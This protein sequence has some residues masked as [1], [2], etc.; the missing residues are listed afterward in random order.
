MHEYF[1]KKECDKTQN[2]RGGSHNA[3]KK[4]M[5]NEAFKNRKKRRRFHVN[6][7]EQEIAKITKRRISGV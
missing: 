1:E 5:K 3:R 4:R 2:R 7:S 6:L